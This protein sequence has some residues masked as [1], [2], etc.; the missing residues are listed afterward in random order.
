MADMTDDLMFFGAPLITLAFDLTGIVYV[1]DTTDHVAFDAMATVAG[2]AARFPHN[3]PMGSSAVTHQTLE[4]TVAGGT[5]IPL[6]LSAYA[7][8]D[9]SYPNPLGIGAGSASAA[10]SIDAI[11]VITQGPP[12]QSAIQSG[13][14]YQ[15]ASG[16]LYPVVG[17]AFD[18][19]LSAVPEPAPFSL[20]ALGLASLALGHRR[21]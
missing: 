20:L 14:S 10:V 13:I 3:T 17:A 12:L 18:G 5:A 16:S 15:T 6:L 2:Q 7:L 21:L 8:A 1:G 9:A 11:R 4:V 19:P